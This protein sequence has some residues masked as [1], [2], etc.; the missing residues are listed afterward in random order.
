LNSDDNGLGVPNRPVTRKP[1]RAV[2]QAGGKGTRLK[3]Y[4]LVLPK[5]MMPVGEL[6]VI[7]ILLRWLRRNG[8]HEAYVTTGHLGHL[9]RTLCGDGSRWDM[10]IQ[11]TEEAE[12]LGTVGALDLI[13]EQLDGTFLVLNGDL[14]TDLDLRAL[15][16]F[17]RAHQAELTISV[18]ET[19]VPIAMGVFEYEKDGRV[20]EF[21]E[22]PT[23][24][25]AANMGVYCMEPSI[26]DLIPKG[27]P[28]G[29]DDL[30]Y[31]MLDEGRP[32][33]VYRHNGQFMDIGRPEDFALAQEM[34]DRGELPMH[35]G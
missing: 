18:S 23:L 20:S 27:V 7:E 28:Y 15:L 22:K 10:Q 9:I 12:P 6:P 32:A 31:R 30:M 5:P 29:F 13:R 35:E 1:L 24:S 19:R 14:I 4:T 2:I 8:V 11:Y 34:A 33:H 26:L 25:Y 3:P 17:H 16:Q 21:R